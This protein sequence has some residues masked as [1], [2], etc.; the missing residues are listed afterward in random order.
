MSRQDSYKGGI[1]VEKPQT[2]VYTVM[3]MIALV[4]ILIACLL[5]FLEGRSF[6][7]W[8]WWKVPNY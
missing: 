8:P 1:P 7:A 6:G 2:N 4:A 3:L 5:L